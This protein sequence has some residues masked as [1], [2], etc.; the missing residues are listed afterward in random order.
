MSGSLNHGAW[1]VIESGN[2]SG[3]ER[4]HVAEMIPGQRRF[5]RVRLP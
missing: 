3:I 2:A 4:V 5:F 1:Q